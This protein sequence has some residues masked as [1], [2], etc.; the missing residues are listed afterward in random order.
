MAIES[1]NIYFPDDNRQMQ[2]KNICFILKTIVGESLQ[3]S[4]LVKINTG[5]NVCIYL[6][7]GIEISMPVLPKFFTTIRFLKK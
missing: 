6:F 1:I 7:D 5:S 2:H 3:F 4:Q